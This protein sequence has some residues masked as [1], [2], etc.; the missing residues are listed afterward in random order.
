MML[1][2]VFLKGLRDQ[3]RGLVG[4]GVGI[5]VL[6]LLEAALWP[7]VRDMMNLEELLANYP[8]PM[9]ELFDLEEF[10]TGTG[11]FNVELYSLL[12]PIL[13]LVYGIGRGARSV[14]GEEEA[15]T[16]DVLL[17]TRISPVSLV[18]QQAA[19]LAVGLAGLGVVLFA[20]VMVFSPVFGLGIGAAAA[21]TG[22]LSMVLLGIE[23]GWL[24]LAVGSATGRRGLAIAV[25]AALAVAGYVLYA[26]G[27]L[28]EAVEPW[29][30]LSP[31][32]Q[33]VEGGPLGAGLP[34]A[35]GWLALGAVVVVLAAL[36]VFHRRD[37][38]AR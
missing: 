23:Y 16:L 18:V 4:W 26:A 6:V 10:T 36:P 5:V 3:R 24:A 22:S 1:R 8:E 38:A 14:A 28:V 29:R 12:L 30:P 20:A 31:F 37:I 19:A 11:F 9:R 33:A 17:L 32:H 2:N 7:S 13:F 35:Y 27:A 34:L 25:S 15:G 21:A